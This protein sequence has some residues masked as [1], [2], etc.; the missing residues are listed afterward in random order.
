MSGEK[1]NYKG[2]LVLGLR[3][4][5]LL[6]VALCF[7][8][9]IW[10]SSDWL[11]AYVLKDSPITPLSVLFMLYGF[12]GAGSIEVVIRLLQRKTDSKN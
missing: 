7:V 11:S 1:T 10:G 8:G 9:L 4:M 6:A 2:A 12:M 3:F 5:Q